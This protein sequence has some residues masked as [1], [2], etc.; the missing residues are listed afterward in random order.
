MAGARGAGTGGAGGGEGEVGD[1]RAGGGAGGA[2]RRGRDRHPTRGR[3]RCLRAPPPRGG[4]LGAPCGGSRRAGG[5]ALCDPRPLW[6]IWAVDGEPQPDPGA[7]P[8]QWRPPALPCGGGGG[9][10]TPPY[11][12]G[13]RTCLDPIPASVP[14]RSPC[15]PRCG[16]GWSL[17]PPGMDGNPHVIPDPVQTRAPHSGARIMRPL[18]FS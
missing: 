9:L 3:G 8:V 12:A 5:G 16:G 4:R 13:E 11:M 7:A 6:G 14:W 18:S 15:G 1:P 2:L 10:C 17:Q